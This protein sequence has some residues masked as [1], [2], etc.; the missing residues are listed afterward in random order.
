[1]HFEATEVGF[2]GAIGG[3]S[4]SDFEAGYHYVLFG[5][6]PDSGD[7]YFE[8]DD[9]AN[10]SVGEVE[11]VVVKKQ[12]VKFVLKAGAMVTVGFQQCQSGWPEF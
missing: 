9:Q 3:A 4:N 11:Q 12:F 8:Y 2:D 10:G 7:V 5:I 1:M 6:D